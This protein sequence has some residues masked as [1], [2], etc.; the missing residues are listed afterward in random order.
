MS[1]GESRVARRRRHRQWRHKFNDMAT[2]TAQG[3]VA[4]VT[5]SR[6]S[7]PGSSKPKQSFDT[8][9]SLSL[10]LHTARN[11]AQFPFLSRGQ[12]TCPTVAAQLL[13]PGK[14]PSTQFPPPPPALCLFAFAPAFVSKVA[15]CHYEI[16]CRRHSK[17]IIEM[18]RHLP[19]EA[20]DG[21][22]ANYWGGE[23]GNI[24]HGTTH[25]SRKNILP[26]GL[27]LCVLDIMTGSDVISQK[28]VN[29]F[30]LPVYYCS[31]CCCCC[32]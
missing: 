31:C 32:F 19:Q 6:L 11:E 18:W 17:Q 4:R 8:A 3:Q 2:G 23:G 15:G 5:Q 28:R 27:G 7:N 1:R 21:N 30:Y 13:S 20:R 22:G 24:R 29:F 10:T 16:C 26:G 25:A 14:H 9:L 12:N